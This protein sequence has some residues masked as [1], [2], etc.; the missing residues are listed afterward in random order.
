MVDSKTVIKD[1]TII[2]DTR[3]STRAPEFRDQYFLGRRGGCRVREAAC[4]VFG[5]PS[6]LICTSVTPPLRNRSPNKKT[7]RLQMSCGFYSCESDMVTRTKYFFI[8]L[9]TFSHNILSLLI[10]VDEKNE[11]KKELRRQMSPRNDHKLKID[12]IKNR[13]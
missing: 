11:Q 2:R 4:A 8:V 3:V 5:W 7:L 6:A 9:C 12:A 13:F 10:L 1:K